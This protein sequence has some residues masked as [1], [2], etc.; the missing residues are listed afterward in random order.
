TPG[1]RFKNEIPDKVTIQNLLTHTSGLRNV[2][3]I[4]R[5]AFTG[6][7][8]QRDID[9]VFAEGTTF[10]DANFGKYNYTNLGYNIYGLAL[11]YQL[12]KKWQDL[13]QERIFSPAGLKHTTAYVS[14]ARA[15]KFKIA[16]PYVISTD[17]IDA[18]KMVRSQLDKT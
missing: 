11:H 8:E 10:N 6:Q 3:L 16:A 9:H 5:L 1:I 4:N 7:I 2:P 18:G 15:K 12:H 14:R 17:A 13:L